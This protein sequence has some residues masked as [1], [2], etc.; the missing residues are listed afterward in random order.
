MQD[1]ERY[2]ENNKIDAEKQRE[3]DELL[4]KMGF[5]GEN[6][7]ELARKYKDLI[8]KVTESDGNKRVQMLI[9]KKVEYIDY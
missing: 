8:A 1:L 9:S 4:S 3:L 7:K 6:K 2:F 5:E